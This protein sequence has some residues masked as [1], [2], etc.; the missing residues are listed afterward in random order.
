MHA[1]KRRP[2]SLFCFLGALNAFG[3]LFPVFDAVKPAQI[4]FFNLYYYYYYYRAVLSAYPF[5]LYGWLTC[6]YLVNF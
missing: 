1:D 4:F 3:Q 6:A 5:R 2:L